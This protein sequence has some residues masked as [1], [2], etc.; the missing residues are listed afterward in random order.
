MGYIF[1]KIIKDV[2]NIE[3]LD[4]TTLKAEYDYL[5]PRGNIIVDIDQ[6]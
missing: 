6:K 3:V 2:S 1:W 4:Y 5:R